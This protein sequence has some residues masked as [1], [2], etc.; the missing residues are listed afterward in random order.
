MSI[1]YCRT[2]VIC[3]GGPLIDMNP[4]WYWTFMYGLTSY[5]RI[6]DI[7][8]SG[9]DY[10]VYNA[11]ENWRHNTLISGQPGHPS[12][13]TREVEFSAMA[14]LKLRLG[15]GRSRAPHFKCSLKNF[16]VKLKWTSLM[17]TT[18]MKKKIQSIQYNVLNADTLPW[19]Q[20]GS[21]V[22]SHQTHFKT[23][24]KPRKARPGPAG[25]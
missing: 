15:S 8:V 1:T 21:P 3:P 16:D 7:F 4:W 12:W 23:C 24:A 9:N 25:V 14:L 20:A 11:S 6:Y 18:N 22:P 19:L 13:A 10:E 17:Y 2:F 5:F